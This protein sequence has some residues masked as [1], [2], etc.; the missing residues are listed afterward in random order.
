MI[1]FLTPYPSKSFRSVLRWP[2]PGSVPPENIRIRSRPSINT[3]TGSILMT[4]TNFFL[5]IK[6]SIASIL[7]RH[8]LWNSEQF[9]RSY[10]RLHYSIWI[11]IFLLSRLIIDIFIIFPYFN[12]LWILAKIELRNWDLGHWKKRTSIFEHIRFTWYTS[13]VF[14]AYSPIHFFT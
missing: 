8:Q 12:A 13:K 4:A 10:C 6:M 14:L 11:Q 2:G 5:I 1:V 7:I 3:E 9:T